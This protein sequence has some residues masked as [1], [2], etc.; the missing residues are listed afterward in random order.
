GAFVPYVGATPA[1]VE[2][3]IAIP[4]EG[5][6]R[7]IPGVRQLYT[8]SSGDGCFISLN[9][10]WGTDMS[11]ALADVRDRM[12]RL[13]LV[14][15]EGADRVFV[16]HFKLETIPVMSFGLSSTGDYDVFMEKVEREILPKLKRLEGVANVELMGYDPRSIMVDIDQQRM[17]A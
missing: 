6:F 5:E 13:R 1:Q 14:L 8:N 17:L 12:E 4:A 7:T 9:F 15:P 11:R 16:R 10:E 3:E 2:Q